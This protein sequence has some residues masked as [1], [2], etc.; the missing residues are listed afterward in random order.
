MRGQRQGSSSVNF[1]R[2]SLV[3]LCCFAPASV[4]AE[5]PEALHLKP[6][7][8]EMQ[9][10]EMHSDRALL[11]PISD[12]D[13]AEMPA[14]QKTQVENMRRAGKTAVATYKTC[15]T[16]QML[17]SFR[18]AGLAADCT[19]VLLQGTAT[20]QHSHISC[21]GSR[22][23]GVMKLSSEN[24]ETMVIDLTLFTRDGKRSRA[25]G[26]YMKGRWISADCGVEA[27]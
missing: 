13:L 27:N 15:V 25:T 26:T 19:S 18:P 7:L 1:V 8:W 11:P 4:A 5:T 17:Q 6:G 24:P 12:E 23:T 10:S 3:A 2:N 21:T 9:S 20:K 16:R 14:S 22:Q